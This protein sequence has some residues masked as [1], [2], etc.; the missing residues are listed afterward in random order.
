MSLFRIVY[1]SRNDVPAQGEDH[2]AEAL[3]IL[4]ASRANNVRDDI[5]GAL[6]Y[7][8]ICFAQVLEGP[9]EAV[10]TTFERIQ[11]DPRHADVVVLQSGPAHERLF[12]S[13][14][15]AAA[16]AAD[17]ATASAAIIRALARPGAS[18]ATEVLHMLAV[19][20]RRRSPALV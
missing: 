12:A 14:D 3:R 1:C 10:Q 9:L 16:T 2:E 5:T 13:W 19:L 17:P 15:M 20:V 18:A 11:C 4:K 6:F 7:N 8:A